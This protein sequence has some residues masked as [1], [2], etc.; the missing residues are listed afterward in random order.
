M[1]PL[2]S[3]GAWNAPVPILCNCM[4]KS[5]YFS[6]F[7]IKNVMQRNYIIWTLASLVRSTYIFLLGY[8]IAYIFY[9]SHQMCGSEC[10][11]PSVFHK[12]NLR[13]MS[14]LVYISDPFF[15]E[16]WHQT[17]VCRGNLR[18][19]W[20]WGTILHLRRHRAVSWIRTGACTD[21]QRYTGRQG[22][23]SASPDR[24]WQ[25]DHPDTTPSLDC[26]E[27][28]KNT[29]HLEYTQAKVSGFGAVHSQISTY[30][31]WHYLNWTAS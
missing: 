6:L 17:A 10:L 19:S 28:D 14:A 5:N 11:A 18:Y 8:I 27:Y 3:F 13:P 1:L 15:F 2:C 22:E 7:V 4:K 9:G 31:I 23:Q 24:F 20:V 16:V 21:E 12:H 29:Q 26:E 30:T 25:E